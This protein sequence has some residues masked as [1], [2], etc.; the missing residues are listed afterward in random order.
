MSRAD[1]SVLE[2]HR[3]RGRNPLPILLF[4]NGLDPRPFLQGIA[5]RPQGVGNQELGS[6]VEGDV[7]PGRVH[8][9]DSALNLLRTGWASLGGYRPLRRSPRLGLRG[10]RRRACLRPN[11]RS[12]HQEG[13]QH[14]EC[15]FHALHLAWPES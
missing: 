9:H 7:A 6:I 14:R 2:P 4:V 10:R 13:E 5:G 11:I 8:A 15:S 12:G 1:P 3:D